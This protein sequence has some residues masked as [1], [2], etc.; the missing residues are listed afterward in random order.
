MHIPGMVITSQNTQVGIWIF[1]D[2]GD[3]KLSFL[4]HGNV[5]L[6]K[7]LEKRGVVGTPE[8]S[9]PSSGG[10]SGLKITIKIW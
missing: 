10:K 9:Q 3:T 4:F 5:P 2:D 7:V 1:L 8:S 6:M